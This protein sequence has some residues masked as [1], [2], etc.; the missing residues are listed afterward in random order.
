MSRPMRARF[1]LAAPER[2][3]GLAAHDFAQ[4][5]CAPRGGADPGR[6]GRGH[7]D[8]AVALAAQARNRVARAGS[9]KTCGRP[10]QARR[11]LG[12][13]GQARRSGPT[14]ACAPP[15]PRPPVEARPRKLS[16]T[17]VETWIRDPYAIYARHIFA[18]R[19][20]EPIDAG[21]RRGR[22]WRFSIHAALDRFLKAHPR[23][24]ARPAPKPNCWRSAPRNSARRWTRPGVRAFWWP[25]FE[26]DRRLVGG[27]WSASAGRHIAQSC[28]E[29]GGSLLRPPGGAFT[30]TAKADRIDRLTDGSLAII[31]YKTGVL[32][33]AER[34]RGRLRAATALGSRHRR[35][36]AALPG[37]AAAVGRLALLAA[38]GRHPPGGEKRAGAAARRRAAWPTRR[39]PD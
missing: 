3:I 39:W 14:E 20:L 11:A 31:D 5:A 27:V 30:L 24:V 6:A 38:V 17:S 23:R 19:P 25:R 36:T 8:R 35:G 28:S 37:V 10:R 18:S 33:I 2:R 21:S 9:R 32:P 7:A 34:G 29:I 26:R 4:A 1:G 13:A 22:S 16:V 15:A 12:L